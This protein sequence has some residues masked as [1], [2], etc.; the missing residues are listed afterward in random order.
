MWMRSHK[1]TTNGRCETWLTCTFILETSCSLKDVIFLLF[2]LQG[3]S[4]NWVHGFIIWKENHPL[5]LMK[6]PSVQRSN[7]ASA[8]K[9]HFLQVLVETSEPGSP[10]LLLLCESWGCS[11]GQQGACCLLSIFV[12]SLRSWKRRMAFCSRHY[13]M[14]IYAAVRLW[15]EPLITLTH[16]HGHTLGRRDAS[17]HTHMR[18]K[19]LSCRSPSVRRWPR[20]LTLWQG[21]EMAQRS[22][23]K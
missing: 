18:S 19:V 22:W 12:C 17:E 7:E 15:R 4:H 3:L 11:L 14:D 2:S 23:L 8:L 13:L 16:T 10:S 1:A 9:M 5:A 6:A 21:G 20:S